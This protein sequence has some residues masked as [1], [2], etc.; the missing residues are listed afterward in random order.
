L[1]DFSSLFDHGDPDKNDG[2]QID[3]VK[4]CFHDSLH[5][6]ISSR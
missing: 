2:G 3:D 5:V 1:P 6:D 4:D